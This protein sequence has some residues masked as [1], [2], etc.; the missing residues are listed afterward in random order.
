MWLYLNVEL[1][2]MKRSLYGFPSL[3]WMRTLI[4]F[5]QIQ[6]VLSSLSDAIFYLAFLRRCHRQIRLVLIKRRSLFGNYTT[7]TVRSAKRGKHA[8]LAVMDSLYVNIHLMCTIHEKRIWK[9]H[10]CS[11]I[12]RKSMFSASLSHKLLISWSPQP[13]E[14]GK[15]CLVTQCQLKSLAFLCFAEKSLCNIV[16][17]AY[18]WRNQSCFENASRQRWTYALYCFD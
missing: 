4:S 6:R 1:V 12:K 2:N 3:L 8:R 18:V 10:I 16:S 15:R 11:I 7:H 9:V 14:N 13:R 17:D 5:M